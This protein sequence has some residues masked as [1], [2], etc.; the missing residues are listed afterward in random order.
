MIFEYIASGVALL[1]IFL[2]WLAYMRDSAGSAPLQD[3][4]P[5][6]LIGWILFFAGSLIL[7]IRAAVWFF[8]RWFT[9]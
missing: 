2:I 9:A 8:G 7:I 6:F 5:M 4:V 3:V 1:G